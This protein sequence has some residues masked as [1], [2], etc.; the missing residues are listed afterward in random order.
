MAGFVVRQAMR[1][2][3][4]EDVIKAFGQRAVSAR[5]FKPASIDTV[6]APCTGRSDAKVRI[7]AFADFEC[8]YCRLISP[9]LKKLAGRYGD[10]VSYCFKV[11]PVKG[12]GEAAVRTSKAAVAAHALGRFWELHDLMYSNFEA[13]SDAE[14]AGYA[15]S[16]GMDAAKFSEVRDAAST[17]DLVAGSKRDGLKLG[18]KSTPAIYFNGKLYQ[19]DKTEAELQDR[20]EEELEW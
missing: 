10:R 2:K 19:G 7:V 3:S 16:A 8:P 4:D 12:H 6:D 5:P 14:V 11:F 20:I 13:H 1:G 15:K 18:V 17:K 9:I